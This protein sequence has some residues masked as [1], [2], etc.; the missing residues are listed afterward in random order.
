MKK[1]YAL[2]GLNYDLILESYPDI[3]EFENILHIYLEDEFFNELYNFINN[4]DYAMAKDAVKG[5]FILAS[6]LKL[7]NL[8]EKLLDIF[9]DIELEEYQNVLKDYEE[10]M[11][12]YHRIKGVFIC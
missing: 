2:C 9:E 4:E 5:L 11:E 7:L 3:Q 12:L 8:Y 6:D 10:M 1:K